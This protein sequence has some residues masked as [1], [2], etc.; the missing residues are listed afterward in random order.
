MLR[1]S[2]ATQFSTDLMVCGFVILTL[3]P[4]KYEN[5]IFNQEVH[6]GLSELLPLFER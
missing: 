5:F 1:K 6:E 2:Q 4:E 3:G